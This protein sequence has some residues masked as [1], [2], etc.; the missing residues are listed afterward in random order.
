MQKHK[1]MDMVHLGHYISRRSFIHGLDPR[2]KILCVILL[3]FV[4]L[5]AEILS[6]ALCTGFF[7][8]LIPV[9]QIS[10]KTFL[11][12]LRSVL[13]FLLLLFLLHLFVTKGTPIPPF[14]AWCVTVTFEG[15]SIGIL[16]T[17]RFA[18][19]ILGAS[20]LTMT[21]P[22]SEL[23]SGLERLLRPLRFMGLP[24]HDVA[25]MV[26]MALRFV[27]TILEEIRLI[28]EAQMA[29]CASF[30]TG[31]MVK[32]TGSLVA[33]LI[34]LL[35]GAFRRAN[36]LTAAMEGRGYSGGPRTT[37]RELRLATRDYGALAAV[38]LLVGLLLF[39]QVASPVNAFFPGDQ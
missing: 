27:P 5:K 9:S 28:K 4:I 10:P 1:G 34:P 39:Q 11:Y 22:P 33:L 3:S 21:T 14:P 29:R 15:L 32:R 16:V 20:F 38:I 19:L 18:L 36:E 25:I 7:L 35:T 6:S 8:A 17:W 37:M 26:S 30:S 24:S 12:S 23:V 31:G 2:I 13:P